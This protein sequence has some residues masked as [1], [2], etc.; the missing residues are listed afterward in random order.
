MNAQRFLPARAAASVAALV[1]AFRFTP[2]AEAKTVGTGTAASCTENA[3][4]DA[5]LLN[6]PGGNVD[7]WCGN[8]MTT[9]TADTTIDGGKLIALVGNLVGPLFQVSSNVSL[10]IMGMDLKFANAGTGNGGA[11]VNNGT[12][13]LDQVDLASNQAEWG[14]GIYN[15]GTLIVSNTTFMANSAQNGCG[16]LQLRLALSQHRPDGGPPGPRSNPSRS[17]LVAWLTE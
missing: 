15:T 2:P 8:L 12:L 7:F 4:R 9:I 13:T 3:L 10:T 1:L 5:L 14:G 17:P 11:I 16:G 6:P